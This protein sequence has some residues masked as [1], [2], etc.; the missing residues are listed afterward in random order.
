MFAKRWVDGVALS[1]MGVVFGAGCAGGSS[2]QGTGATVT[3]PGATVPTNNTSVSGTSGTQS[4]APTV[5][6]VNNTASAPSVTG[7]GTAGS[8]VTPPPPMM[9]AAGAGGASAG[10][11]AAAQPPTM[12]NT[13]TGTWDPKA[14]LDASGNLIAPAAGQG[15]QIVTTAFDLMPGQEIFNCFHAE[16]PSDTDFPVGEW[17]GQMTAGSHHFIL[18][19][20]D[21]D[22]TAANTL[23]DGG[24]TLGFGGSSWLYTQGSPRSHLAFPDGVAMV[25]SAHE[26]IVFDMH[27]LNTT[28]NVIHADIKLNLNRVKAENYMKAGSQVSFNTGIFVP[29]MGTQTVSGDCPGIQG[30]N[31]F[32]MQ[33]HMHHFGTLATISRQLA[34]GMPGEE[35]VRTVDWDKPQAHVWMQ[36]PFLTFMPGETFHYSCSYQNDT[37]NY[38]TVGTS[39]QVNEMCM[40]EAY[41]FPADGEPPACN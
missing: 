39:A 8:P 21:A 10:M 34:N 3:A 24:C 27:Y 15:Y 30:A 6:P 32:V 25:V 20:D 2:S 19:R 37:D 41:Y 28:Q 40:A 1:L 22:T 26:R 18:Y 9:V 23:T 5:N 11:M 31:Y 12:M 35:L 33:T 29:P 4:T 38:V 7:S 13:S 14:N 36:A 16:V 17:D